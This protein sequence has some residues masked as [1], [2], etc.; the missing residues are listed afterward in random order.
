MATWMWICLILGIMIGAGVLYGLQWGAHNHTKLV[1]RGLNYSLGQAWDAGPCV[2]GCRF[3]M[4]CV[5]RLPY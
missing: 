5:E 4:D 1:N 2:C 3:C